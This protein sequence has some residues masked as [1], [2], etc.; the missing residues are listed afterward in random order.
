MSTTA[1]PEAAL[2][3]MRPSHA[4]CGA[5]DDCRRSYWCDDNHR[6][7]PCVRWDDADPT[8][9][10]TGSAP[11]NCLLE[12]QVKLR[13]GCARDANESSSNQG[14]RVPLNALTATWLSEALPGFCGP[15]KAG[16]S[17]CLRGDKGSWPLASLVPG[18][19]RGPDYAYAATRACIR[20][21]LRCARC[22]AISVSM[23]WDDCSWFS[24]CELDYLYHEVRSRCVWP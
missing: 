20:R 15:T 10:I 18:K 9:S 3:G 23:H 2:S 14:S 19:L 16:R 5:H 8:A 7:Q 12:F 6:C 11:P 13:D 17:D 1:A 21:C 4:K 22:R 24:Y